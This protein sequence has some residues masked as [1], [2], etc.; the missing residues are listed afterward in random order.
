MADK[1]ILVL[2]GDDYETINTALEFT[3]ENLSE[4]HKKVVRSIDA[5][6]ADKLWK[7][8][9]SFIEVK[10]KLTK[11]SKKDPATEQSLAFAL[12][13]LMAA[14]GGE[15]GDS[16]AQEQAWDRAEKALKAN[17]YE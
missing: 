2:D 12:M 16:L 17:G 7:S 8:A 14:E 15:P 4:T 5:D 10:E 11:Q 3:C 9:M 6:A 1:I 13:D